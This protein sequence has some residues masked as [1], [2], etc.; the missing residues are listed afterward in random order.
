MY[1]HLYSQLLVSSLLTG[2]VG[3]WLPG[4]MFVAGWIGLTAPAMRSLVQGLG[5]QPGSR[6]EVIVLA[7][8]GG[9][10][11]L[12]YG[13]I[14]NLWFW[15]FMSG[16]ADLYWQ[17]GVGL[18]EVFRRYM[19]FY[20]ATSLLWDVLRLAGNTILI[21]VF[22]AATLRALRRFQ[23][24]FGFDYTGTPAP[25]LERVPES[26]GFTGSVDVPA[27]SLSLNRGGGA[28]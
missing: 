22:G 16:P 3:P 23:Q 4:Q 8:F 10:W 7:I 21:L 26:E 25:T 6:R 28:L 19:A 11:G 14:M 15:P 18:G 1:I 5:G 9:L 2:G 17:A 20:V 13:M 27:S 12:A 24:R